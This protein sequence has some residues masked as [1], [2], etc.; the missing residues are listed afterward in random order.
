MDSCTNAGL[1]PAGG[2]GWYELGV[3]KVVFCTQ[4]STQDI[5]MAR[6]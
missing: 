6:R 1:E 2:F 4:S 3:G 5:P